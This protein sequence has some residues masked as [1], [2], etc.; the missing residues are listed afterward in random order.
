MSIAPPPITQRSWILGDAVDAGPCFNSVSMPSSPR[1][2]HG[3]FVSEKTGKFGQF[4]SLSDHA[5]NRALLHQK[6]QTDADSARCHRRQS[7]YNS[8]KSILLDSSDSFL[9][10]WQS[11]SGESSPKLQ[12][13]NVAHQDP[14]PRMR[15]KRRGS[16]TKFS[17]EAEIL[18][19]DIEASDNDDENT[20]KFKSFRRNETL[21]SDE[22]LAEA[23]ENYRYYSSR[24]SPSPR[25]TFKQALPSHEKPKQ[26]TTIDQ[27]PLPIKRSDSQGDR[28]SQ[29]PILDQSLLPPAPKRPSSLHSRPNVS[30]N[31]PIVRE[32]ERSALNVNYSPLSC[33]SEANG[34]EKVKHRSRM[35]QLR[36]VLTSSPRLVLGKPTT[37]LAKQQ[38]RG[39]PSPANRSSQF[40]DVMLPTAPFVH[41][42]DIFSSRVKSPRAQASRK[43]PSNTTLQSEKR[44][45]SA[46]KFESLVKR[47]N[48]QRN[49]SVKS[50]AEDSVH[51]DDSMA[52]SIPQQEKRRLARRASISTKNHLENSSSTPNQRK[53]PGLQRYPSPGGKATYND[54][55]HHSS[56]S[57]RRRSCKDCN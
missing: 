38:A 50:F 8:V 53:H 43:H 7:I 31:S 57:R 27:M 29:V 54:G 3:L 35:P 25:R 2:P 33:R 21:Q 32:S 37:S 55:S 18:H 26:L 13:K 9:P 17:L 45:E 52:E 40:K 48:L 10:L 36:H 4:L 44:R 30:P 24:T 23:D 16:C 28:S 42:A 5:R 6:K 46:P 15:Y 22:V 12:E 41:D 1:T 56:T 14:S 19:R 20:F 39:S 51:D 49:D 11:S 34:S 47:L